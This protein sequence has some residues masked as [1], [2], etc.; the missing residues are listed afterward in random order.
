[1]QKK[2]CFIGHV[3]SGKSST[4][5]HLYAQCGGLSDHELEKM[6]QDTKKEKKEYQLWSRVLDIFEEEQTKGKTHEFNI[7]KLKYNN[8]EF[9]MIDTPGHR[10]F[11]RSL[12]D[13]ISYFKANEIIA[14]L[15]IS[16]SKGEFEAGW[17][18]GQTKEDIILVRSIGIRHLIV[19]I[20]KMDTIEY[21]MKV[22]KEIIEKVNP[23]I[24]RCK[25]QTVNYVAISGYKGENLTST[26]KYM[27][28][29]RSLM[30]II[31]EIDIG[32]TSTKTNT[33]MIKETEWSQMLCEIMILELDSIISAGFM[34]MLHYDGKEYEIII[35]KI[36]KRSYL[37]KGDTAKVIIITAQ[38][39]K[40]IREKETS[41]IIL[42]YQNG[43][44]G[45]GKILKVK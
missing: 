31:D 38:G 1:M 29:S 21:D 41:N 17:I 19:V 44:I 16:A 35:D 37:K 6:Q 22:Y 30:S 39:T 33:N 36:I 8:K 18:K 24:R 25:F 45:F 34:C 10:M 27:P 28:E 32:D 4:A 40:F 26:S 12:I 9:Q 20:N 7:I 15:I 3:D 42:R 2:I 43:T 14:C 13:G 11:V 5:G 23:F